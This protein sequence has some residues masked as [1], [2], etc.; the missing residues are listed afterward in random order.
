MNNLDTIGIY[1][2]AV[3]S[4]AS[5]I[6]KLTPNTVDNVILAKVIKLAETLGLNSKPVNSD[7]VRRDAKT[8]K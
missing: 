8:N 3:I 6:V 5:V 1:V 7:L 4:I 2:A